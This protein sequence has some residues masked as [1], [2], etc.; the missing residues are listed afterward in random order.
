[1]AVKFFPDSVLQLQVT[2]YL[3]LLDGKRLEVLED[4]KEEDGMYMATIGNPNSQLGKRAP[5]R[6]EEKDV[7][8]LSLLLNGCRLH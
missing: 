7:L 4:E 1:M 6:K 5:G 3:A 8:A 2:G